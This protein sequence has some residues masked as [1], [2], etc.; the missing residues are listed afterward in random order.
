MIHPRLQAH[1]IAVMALIVVV[2]RPAESASSGRADHHIHQTIA[3]TH[4]TLPVS[5]KIANEGQKA[6]CTANQAEYE[7]EHIKR[8]DKQSIAREQARHTTV[9][10]NRG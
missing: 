5:T 3:P 7:P 4:T 9:S 6:P 8:H 1:R 2:T 10:H